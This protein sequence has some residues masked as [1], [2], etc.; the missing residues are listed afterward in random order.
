MMATCQH[1]I[2]HLWDYLDGELAAEE[3]EPIAAHLAECGR[4]YPQYRF[5][6]A[7]L[8]LLVRA[9]ERMPPPSRATV[10]R[11]RRLIQPGA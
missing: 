2:E 10:D 3:A 5:E 6:F 1:V 9:R 8:S 7:F 4:C 11:M